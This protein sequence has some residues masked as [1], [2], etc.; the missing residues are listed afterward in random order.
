MPGPR[1]APPLV[2]ALGVLL[3]AFVPAGDGHAHLRPVKPSADTAPAPP[4]PPRPAAPPEEHQARRAVER[5]DFYDAANPDRGRL[6]QMEEATRDLPYDALGFPDWMRA[7]REKKLSLRYSVR[8][9]AKPELLDL[10]VIMRNTKEM[11]NVRFPHLSHTMWLACSNCHPAPF[12]AEK[13]ANN[14]R[15]ADIFR[16][17]YCGMCHDRVAFVTFFSCFRCHSVPQQG[18]AASAP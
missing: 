11:P 6:Q 8:G 18:G 10:D 5:I 15:M 7:L 12:K 3:L 2:L 14:I 1:T 16:G 17:Q 4:P 9:D 13:G